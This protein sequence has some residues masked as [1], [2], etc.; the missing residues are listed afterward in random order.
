MSC[1][2]SSSP[3]S[4]ADGIAMISH[5]LRNSLGVVRNAARLLRL[6]AGADGVERAR[7]LIERH[8]VQMNRHVEHLL[9]PA[10]VRRSRQAPQLSRVDLRTILEHAAEAI[11][12]DS[13]R[14]NQRLFV[15][16][17]AEALWVNADAARLEQ[18]FLNLLI[19]ATKYTPD[20]GQITLFM[21]RLESHAS[22]RIIDSG[23]GIAPAQLSRIFEMFVRLPSP[24]SD[25]EE[26]SG[27][28][29][30]VVRNL[31]AMHGGTVRATSAGVGL[32]SEFAV[33][34]PALMCD[35][36]P[37]QMCAAVTLVPLVD[38]APA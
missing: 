1:M 6:Q 34:L 31:V 9:D 5:E 17:P 8:V 26:G 32:G 2:N 22:I 20:G 14:R 25:A 15:R 35:L 4:Y 28:G 3:D 24:T 11:S 10:T 7:I 27:I 18:V 19:N 37:T 29:L 38:F 23:I 13:A 36:A 21:E 16:L 12:P 30:A 33:L